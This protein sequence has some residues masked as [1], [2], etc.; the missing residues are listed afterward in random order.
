[1]NHYTNDDATKESR[2]LIRELMNAWDSIVASA[3][4]RFPG[5]TEE[6]IYQIASRAM[7]RALNIP[8]NS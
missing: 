6:E 3:R 2:E 4:K 8:L 7:K 1:M 5:A